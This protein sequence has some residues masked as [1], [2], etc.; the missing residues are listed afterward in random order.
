MPISSRCLPRRLR[1]A[2]LAHGAAAALALLPATGQ[3]DSL[4]STNQAI[5]S[6]AARGTGANYSMITQSGTGNFASTEQ[7]GSS[8]RAVISQMGDGNSSLIRQSAAGDSATHI[9]IGNG[10]TMV[11]TQTVPGQ[12]IV[13]TQH[14]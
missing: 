6:Q 4:V 8:A 12:H 7:M 1:P 2:M 11:I 5:L 13:V 10:L 3:A 9:Q 14:R